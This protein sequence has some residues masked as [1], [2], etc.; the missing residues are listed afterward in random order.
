MIH[1]T[2]NQ[3]PKLFTIPL[4]KKS[5]FTVFFNKHLKH[6]ML[7]NQAWRLHKMRVSKKFRIL[8]CVGRLKCI[9]EAFI[10]VKA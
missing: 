8:S 2:V 9:Q 5:V 4:K 3:H 7:N 10:F 1:T 6:L